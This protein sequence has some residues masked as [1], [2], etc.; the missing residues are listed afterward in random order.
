MK[1][2]RM[3]EVLSAVKARRGADAARALELHAKTMTA[4]LHF[5]HHFKDNG[6]KT[7]ARLADHLMTTNLEMAARLGVTMD[8]SK[9]VA[10]ALAGDIT[11]KTPE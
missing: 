9:M 10:T 1:F 4:L 8:E 7:N 3:D 6:D 2:D 5:E 11:T